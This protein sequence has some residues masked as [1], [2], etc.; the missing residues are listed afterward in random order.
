MPCRSDPTRLK[1]I[2]LYLGSVKSFPETTTAESKQNMVSADELE[3]STHA[4]KGLAARKINDL[5]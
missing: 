1:T 3:P 5:H 4:L 2:G